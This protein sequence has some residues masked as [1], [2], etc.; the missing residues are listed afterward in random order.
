MKNEFL[1]IAKGLKTKTELIE[2]ENEKLKA[3]IKKL[4]EDSKTYIPGL[5]YKTTKKFSMSKLLGALATKNWDH[6]G[7]EKEILNTANKDLEYSEGTALIPAQIVNEIYTELIP[8]SAV[9]KA[10]ITQFPGVKGT[11]DFGQLKTGVTVAYGTGEIT[12]SEPGIG[13]IPA[14]PKEMRALINVNNT[15]L[16]NAINGFS[17]ALEKNVYQKMAQK[18]DYVVLRG[19]GSTA[20]PKGVA[21]TSN[22][23]TVAIGTTGGNITFDHIL[24]MKSKLMG[25]GAYKGNLA[26]I[27]HPSVYSQL[28]SKVGT[29]GHYIIPNLTHEALEA[30][31]G[32]KVLVSTQI[33]I[34]LT[35]STGTALSEVYLG[36]WS[37][38]YFA[39]W[40][41]MVVSVDKSNRFDYNQTA[42]RFIWNNDG[43]VVEPK[44]FCLISDANAE[45]QA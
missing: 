31:V 40:G 33:P 30:F 43:A 1:E 25:N 13:S 5:D 12:A 44:S 35:K 8:E 19:A 45:Y 37:D 21:Q 2:S 4:T 6:A 17:T 22:I 9:L 42:F 34:D 15:M 7:L 26:Y 36:N 38:Y 11:I 14:Y 28:I 29:D 24:S 41:D 20:G 3:Q 16:D 23:E 27:M 32:C 10:G 18:I 39:S